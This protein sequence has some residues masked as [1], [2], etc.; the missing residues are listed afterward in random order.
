M[1]SLLRQL[2]Q[3]PH[4]VFGSIATLAPVYQPF[5]LWFVGL[6][7]R[8]QCGSKSKNC[9]LEKFSHCFSCTLQVG[10]LTALLPWIFLDFSSN[11]LYSSSW[12]KLLLLEGV[13]KCMCRASRKAQ[14]LNFHGILANQ[15]DE[16]HNDKKFSYCFKKGRRR[17]WLVS[18][19]GSNEQCCV[20]TYPS[21]KMIIWNA[22]PQLIPSGQAKEASKSRYHYLNC[23]RL[24]GAAGSTREWGISTQ[25]Q[26][27]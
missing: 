26:M 17:L 19:T 10:L 12:K 13:C 1:I 5:S 23:I 11:N 7:F 25:S 14:L 9:D 15:V 4:H 27:R 24:R 16:L 22:S 2:P 21:L 6:L 18:A 3:K 8:H 20:A